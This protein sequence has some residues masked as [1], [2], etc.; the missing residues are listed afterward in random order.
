MLADTLS[1]TAMI[2]AGLVLPIIFLSFSIVSSE[3]P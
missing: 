3:E 2:F 1:P